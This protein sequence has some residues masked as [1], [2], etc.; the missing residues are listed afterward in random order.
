MIF[1]NGYKLEHVFLDGIGHNEV[2]DGIFAN[3]FD[4]KNVLEALTLIDFKGK[5]VLPSGKRFEPAL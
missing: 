4:L 2:S 3:K 1:N 5:I